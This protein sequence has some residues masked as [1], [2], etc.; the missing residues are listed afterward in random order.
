M[1]QALAF[2]LISSFTESQLRPRLRSF[3]LVPPVSGGLWCHR[4]LDPQEQVRSGRGQWLSGR[5]QLVGRAVS[6]GGATQGDRYVVWRSGSRSVSGRDQWGSQRVS[7][8][9]MGEHE[10]VQKRA[11]QPQLDRGSRP[12]VE[13]MDQRGREG[14][15]GPGTGPTTSET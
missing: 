5:H 10:S 2:Y 1:P 14:A 7:L 4:A 8:V 11:R 13:E 6:E 12:M 9:R 3:H 15:A